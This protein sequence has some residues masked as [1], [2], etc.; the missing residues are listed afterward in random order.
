MNRRTQMIVL[1]SILALAAVAA[2]VAIPQLVEAPRQVET[3]NEA[4][5]TVLQSNYAARYVNIPYSRTADGGFVLGSPDAPI[6]IVEFADFL[7]P[8]CQTYN[9]TVHQF[10]EQYVATGMAKFEYRMFPIIDAEY[11]AF[12]GQ[13]AECADSQTPGM[14]WAA[15]DLLFD[16]ASRGSIDRQNTPSTLA[17]A[18][19]L[20]ANLLINCTETAAQF[21]TDFALGESLGVDGTPATLVRLEDDSLGYVSLDGQVFDSGG[22]PLEVLARVIEAENPR[23]VVIVYQPILDGLIS[24]DAECAP[25]CWRGITPGE[26]PLTQAAE[27]IA[28]QPDLGGIAE[29]SADDGSGAKLISWNTIDGAQC[30]TMF[31]EG[32]DGVDELLLRATSLTIGQVI[33]RRGDPTAA[34]TSETEQG[35]Y[36]VSLFYPQDQMIVYVYVA[37]SS[38]R[39]F[40]DESRVAAASYLSPARYEQGMVEIMPSPWVG[41]AAML[42]YISLATAEPEPQITEEAVTPETQP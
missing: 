1:V 31:S 28:Q 20:D 41:Y 18:L 10:I 8:H 4:G 30:C 22:L 19:S 11:S 40:T 16:L 9:T 14:F 17:E 23:D 27:I 38:P 39:D 34:I 36:L 32:S 7:C 21:E 5:E 12:A 25:P 13:L 6:T 35:G 42:Q 24:D 29:Q 15:H 26:T 3:V 37:G 2:V 33:A